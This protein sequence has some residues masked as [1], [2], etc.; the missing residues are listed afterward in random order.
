MKKLTIPQRDKTK[1]AHPKPAIC[2]KDRA[3]VLFFSRYG[4]AMRKL[5]NM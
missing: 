5:A 3:V 2:D 1:V 4:E